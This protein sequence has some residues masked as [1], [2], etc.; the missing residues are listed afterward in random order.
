MKQARYIFLERTNIKEPFLVNNGLRPLT[1]LSVLI[2]IFSITNS[3]AY[4][5]RLNILLPM[6]SPPLATQAHLL[7]LLS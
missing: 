2:S 5:L 3:I 4:G 1:G 6:F 7:S